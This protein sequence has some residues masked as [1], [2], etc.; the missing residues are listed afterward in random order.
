MSPP[1]MGSPSHWPPSISPLN[2]LRIA[3]FASLLVADFA[4][5]ITADGRPHGNMMRPPSV[6]LIRVDGPIAPV[7]S[8]NG[9]QLPPYNQTFWFDQL[10]DHNNPGLGTFKQRFWHTWEFY[11]SGAPTASIAPKFMVLTQP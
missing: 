4:R 2:M 3:L 1:A 10:V 8:R 9:T 11:E 6:P 7:V 5:A